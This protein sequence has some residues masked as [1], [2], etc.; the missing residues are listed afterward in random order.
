MKP[1]VA[2][3]ASAAFPACDDFAAGRNVSVIHEQNKVAR[4]VAVLDE[5]VDSRVSQPSGQCSEL[6]RLLL[7]E[8]GHDDVAYGG[9]TDPCS[10]DG[11]QR[12]RTV[13]DEVVRHRMSG[14][15]EN[16]AAF[17]AHPGTA[18]RLSEVGQ[19]AWPVGQQ[20]LEVLQSGTHAATT[21]VATSTRMHRLLASGA[22]A[23]WSRE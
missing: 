3:G 8:P 15:G 19:C 16:P 20:D 18:E 6:S 13:V 9:W 12:G 1:T 22:S 21:G 5:H 14:M 17:Q 2:E 4:V 11:G 23:V 7:V 10:G